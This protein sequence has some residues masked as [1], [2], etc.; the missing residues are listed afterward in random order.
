MDQTAIYID[1]AGKTTR[2]FT[3]NYTIDVPRAK[4]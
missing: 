3:G 4:R 2:D 1:M